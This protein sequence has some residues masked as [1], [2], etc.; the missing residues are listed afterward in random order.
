MRI[1]DVVEKL[2]N[3]LAL[4]RKSVRISCRPEPK[5]LFPTVCIG[6]RATG[7]GRAASLFGVGTLKRE[8]PLMMA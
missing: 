7:E 3:E 6:R 5:Q 2:V 4:P 8:L 1:S